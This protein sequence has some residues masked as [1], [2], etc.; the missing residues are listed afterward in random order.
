MTEGSTP[1]AG[2]GDEA[3][4]IED[5]M[6]QHPAESAKSKRKHVEKQ[7]DKPLGPEDHQ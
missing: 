5:E 7:G 1:L 6:K 3:T 4:P 2:E